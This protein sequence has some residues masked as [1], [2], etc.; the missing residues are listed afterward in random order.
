MALRSLACGLR[1]QQ[2]RFLR[3]A[4]PQLNAAR[5]YASG[6][7]QKVHLVFVL[8]WLAAAG[9]LQVQT[10]LWHLK[11]DLVIGHTCLNLRLA[12]CLCQHFLRTSF[13]VE[14]LSLLAAQC[15]STACFITCRLCNLAV[16]FEV[17]FAHSVRHM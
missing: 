9:E 17:H 4:T 6:G 1:R 12:L 3:L 2:D 14:Y 5:F 10:C 7:E 8:L 16:I 11:R 15:Y 13:T